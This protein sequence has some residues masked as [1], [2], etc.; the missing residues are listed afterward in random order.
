MN[1]LDFGRNAL[2]IFA[3]AVLLQG[4]G[5]SPPLGV[6]GTMPQTSV[7]VP[8]RTVHRP[9]SQ[10]P[11][12]VLHRFSRGS[13]G[14][15][16]DAGLI[17]VKGTLYG[18]TSHGGVLHCP[19]SCGVVYSIST[20]GKEK[21]L[22]RFT[23]NSDGALPVDGLVDVKGRLY[24]T[25]E[26]GGGS[27]CALGGCGTVYSISTSGKE[28]VLYRFTGGSDGAYPDAGLIEVKGT[29][30]GTTS[31]G[32]SS[33][34]GTVYSIST[35]GVEKVLHNFAGGSD[36][37]APLVELI[38][39]KGT[40]YGTTVNG[41]LSACSGGCGTV[42]SISTNGVEN[43]LYRFTGASGA[44]PEAA[45]IEVNG[46]LYGTTVNGG[47]SRCSGGC[48]TVYSIS[49]TG[50]EKVLH[51]FN[52]GSDGA[53]PQAG[54]IDV[55]GALYGTTSAGGSD[56]YRKFSCGIVFDMEMLR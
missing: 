23:G 39:V 20:S 53:A 24:G 30:Y 47:V 3:A 10:W 12:Q 52:G 1:S 14:A 48:G 16:P 56:C 54:L 22:Y 27:P 7:I 43:V 21:V 6:P 35:S 25:T 17:N 15:T 2:L 13:D 11:F 55:K 51:R 9:Q 36:G 19:G 31:N 44:Y 8:A 28:K 49:T 40:L 33:G 50:V 18:T 32:G 45:L 5:G 26:A 46:R 29:L 41:G 38:D 42:Y 34:L 4:C 37:A